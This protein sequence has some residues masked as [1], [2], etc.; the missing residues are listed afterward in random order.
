MLR[1]EPD[2]NA[3]LILLNSM[4]IT[5][6]ERIKSLMAGWTISDISQRVGLNSSAIRYYERIGLVP[7]PRRESGQRRYASSDVDL[8][9]VIRR[10]RQ[11]GFTVRE[12]RQ[13][14]TSASDCGPSKGWSTVSNA[15]LAELDRKI[16]E[17]RSLKDQLTGIVMKCKCR[18]LEECGRRMQQSRDQTAIDLL[19]QRIS[20]SPKI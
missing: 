3:S 11:L 8:L 4:S 14:C 19:S 2:L 12:V 6:H 20:W 9:T 13:L 18:S 1:L 15:K 5:D 16:V 10:A 7:P 17:I